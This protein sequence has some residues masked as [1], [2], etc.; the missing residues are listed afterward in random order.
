[1]GQAK[2][3]GTEEERIAQALEKE[4]KNKKKARRFFHLCR[5][6]SPRATR[7]SIISCGRNRGF[8]ATSTDDLPLKK[9]KETS[10]L[11]PYIAMSTGLFKKYN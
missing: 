6:V 3:R 11:L 7:Q 4:I 1:M 8:E 9:Y 10:V 2:R 5:F